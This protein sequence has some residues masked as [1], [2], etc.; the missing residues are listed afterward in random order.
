MR[1]S[2]HRPL[3]GT[4]KAG[5]GALVVLGLILAAGCGKRVNVT[6]K[7]LENGKPIAQA[8]LRLASESDAT[9]FVSG[10]SDQNGVYMLDTAGKRG[11][12]P[13]RYKVSITWWRLRDGKPLPE[14]EA[15]S[16][17][18][19]TSKVRSFSAELST[20]IKADSSSV[21]LDVTGKVQ[22]GE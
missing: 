18:R 7:V 20:E 16:A 6:G 10:I 12:P 1:C 22:A 2:C 11:I 19:G 17:L 14:G 3:R 21:D 9:L 4:A 5:L 8:E 13:G 15:G